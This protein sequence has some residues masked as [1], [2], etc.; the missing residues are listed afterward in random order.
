MI[1]KNCNIIFLDKIE[2][3]SVLIKDGKIIEINPTNF[4]CDDVIDGKDLYL[5]P[6][7][8]DVH[9]HGSGGYDTMNSN[10]NSI[11]EISKIICK[12]G[13]T[14]FLPTTMTMSPSNISKAL[15]SIKSAMINGTDGAKVLGAHL[16]GPFINPKAIG[17]Q[18]PKF[19]MKPSLENYT[20]LVGNN[21]DSVVSITM[22]PEIK[23]A[24]ELAEYLSSTG[25]ICS[26]GHT[27]ANYEEAITGINHGFS[28]ATH[29][30]NTM[31]PFTHR[32]PGTVGAIFNTDIS[33]E[34][35]CDGIH[36]SYPALQIAF[37]QKGTDKMLLVTD[38]I[39]A[40]GLEDGNYLLG[41]Q[42]VIV[43]NGVAR[44]ENGI[45]AGSTLTLNIAVKNIYKNFK[46]PL[47]E[48]IKMA[49]F[50]CAKFCNMADRKG[51]IKAGYD[52]DLILF[53]DDINVKLTIVEGQ[54][55]YSCLEAE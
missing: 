40:C 33:T 16:E 8:I 4:S 52:A 36:I 30:F 3:G 20:S 45:L 1:I 46:Y 18:N 48:V 49:S 37:K 47:N 44:L 2:K 7:F 31:T 15:T 51:Q 29:L 11:N 55:V 35:I 25:I 54:I 17:A 14:A 53:D 6:G 24:N 23:G 41:G 12:Y 26:I 42:N 50:N 27:K 21:G 28:H 19:L 10:Y 43:K 39:E 5:S 38:S 22:A 32:N 9:I 34:I 13:T